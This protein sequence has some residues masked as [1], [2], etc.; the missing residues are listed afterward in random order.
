VGQHARDLVRRVF[1]HLGHQQSVNEFDPR[2]VEEFADALI[3]I[4][5]HPIEVLRRVHRLSD[6][7]T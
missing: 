6:G 4:D 5:G 3:F 2:I 1:N 7:G